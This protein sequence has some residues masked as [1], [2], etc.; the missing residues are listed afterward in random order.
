MLDRSYINIQFLKINLISESEVVASTM[1]KATTRK[2]K[3]K[4]K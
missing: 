2:N 1:T 3:S 4:E